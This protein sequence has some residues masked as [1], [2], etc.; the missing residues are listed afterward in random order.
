ML[1]AEFG[2]SQYIGVKPCLLGFYTVLLEPETIASHL[3]QA[4]P[5]CGLDLL[6]FVKSLDQKIHLS[7]AEYLS[8]QYSL[9]TL[10]LRLPS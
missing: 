8:S 3:D 5:G 7:T 9:L 2:C 10:T 4:E 1:G 6:E